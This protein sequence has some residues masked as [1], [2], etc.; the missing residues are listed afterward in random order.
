MRGGVFG[1]DSGFELLLD[2][3]DLLLLNGPFKNRADIFPLPSSNCVKAADA[4]AK[5]NRGGL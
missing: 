2:S 4:A 5:T 3:G 1:C